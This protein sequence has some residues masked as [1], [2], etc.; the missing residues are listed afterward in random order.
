MFLRKL[1]ECTVWLVRYGN[2]LVMLLIIVDNGKKLKDEFG[3][4]WKVVLK[5]LDQIKGMI[6]SCQ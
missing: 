5:V 6:G 3:E 2:M 1:V 4:C